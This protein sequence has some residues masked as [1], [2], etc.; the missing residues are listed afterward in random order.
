MTLTE[1]VRV[2]QNTTLENVLSKQTIIWGRDE[3]NPDHL[4]VIINAANEG[5][6]SMMSTTTG[7]YV[8]QQFCDRLKDSIDRKRKIW[9]NKIF[10]KI[11]DNLEKGGKQL[12]EKTFYNQTEYIVFQKRQTSDMGDIGGQNQR[13]NV[14]KVKVN[15]NK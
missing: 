15:M 14:K 7:S 5:F 3:D 12:L 11:Q 13:L 9:L 10:F 2:H 6:Q 4:L 8:I 1:I